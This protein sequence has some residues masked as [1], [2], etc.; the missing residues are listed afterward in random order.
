[1]SSNWYGEFE[2][3]AASTGSVGSHTIHVAGGDVTGDVAIGFHKMSLLARLVLRYDA[4]G[5]DKFTIDTWFWLRRMA[6]GPSTIA[7]NPLSPFA[8]AIVSSPVHAGVMLYDNPVQAS[9]TD[10]CRM[11]PVGI[12]IIFC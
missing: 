11:L 9:M 8:C 12:F 2:D 4:V 1:M 5:H 6:A 10:N 3:R 7:A